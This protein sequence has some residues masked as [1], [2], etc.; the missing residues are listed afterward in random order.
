MPSSEFI[1]SVENNS[2]LPILYAHILDYLELFQFFREVSEYVHPLYAHLPDIH[3]PI[4]DL[5]DS[6]YSK[7]SLDF[8]QALLT[9]QTL[10]LS[11]KFLYR[12]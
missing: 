8:L 12:Q 6:L 10:L 9:H 3:I 7:L 4:Q 5:T 11:D 2:R 1:L